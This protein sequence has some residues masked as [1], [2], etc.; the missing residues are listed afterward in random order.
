[1]KMWELT[2]PGILQLKERRPGFPDVASGV[3]VTQVLQP[4]SI[5]LP[6]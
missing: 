6:L 4:L 1:M 2:K 3:L 5:L